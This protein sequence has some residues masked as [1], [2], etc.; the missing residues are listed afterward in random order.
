MLLL[1]VAA[2]TVVA[3]R[4]QMEVPESA[5]KHAPDS[6]NLSSQRKGFRRYTTDASVKLLNALCK[7]LL[8]VVV[9]VRTAALCIYVHV[10]LTMCLTV[11]LAVIAVVEYAFV[12]AVPLQIASFCVFSRVALSFAGGGGEVGSDRGHHAS[13]VRTL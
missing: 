13:H 3:R 9:V 4:Y 11:L 12:C 7:V 8:D 5:A 1:T 10:R 2:S 6:Y